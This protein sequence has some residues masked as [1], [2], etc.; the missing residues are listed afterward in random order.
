[1]GAT[2]IA[3]DAL[4]RFPSA[5]PCDP[6]VEAWLAGGDLL[7]GVVEPWL[8]RL[9]ACGPD[10]RELMHDGRPTVCAGEAAFAYLD[11]YTEHASIGFFFGASLD[12]P[13]R[14]LEGNGKRMRHVKLRPGRMP[15]EAALSGLI[16]AAYRDICRR[17]DAGR[18]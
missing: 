10:V 7:H 6:A 13:A 8:E 12:D 11:A 5:R 2:V 16:S 3:Q 17:L 9:R 18:S 15:D 1:M 14:L 4:F